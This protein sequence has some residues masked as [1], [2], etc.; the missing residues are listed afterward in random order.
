MAT[1]TQTEGKEGRLDLRLQHDG[2]CLRAVTHQTIVFPTTKRK[3]PVFNNL[4]HFSRGFLE[5]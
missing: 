1:A 2:R 5:Q 4:Q 3:H